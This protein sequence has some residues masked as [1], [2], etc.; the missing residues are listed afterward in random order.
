MNDAFF[1]PSL[2]VESFIGE[3]SSVDTERF[4]LF[5]KAYYEWMQ[6]TTL[7]LTN[8]AGTFVVG[9]TIV[10]TI[11]GAI[12]SI[13]EVKTN[14][15]VIAPTSRTVF[16]YAE[17]LTGQTSGATATINVIKDNVGRASGNILNYKNL[18]IS[19]DKY[20]DYL[21]EELYPSIPAT[22]YGDK[23]LVAQ[24]FKDFY[25]SKSNEQSYRFLFKLLYNEDI[26]FYY[27][28]EDI[29][30]VSDG[31][32]EKT[33]IIRTEA[34]A[35]GVNSS[36]NSFDRDI[37]L[38]LNKTIRGQTSGV[39]ANVVDIKKFFIGS[40]EI[41]EMT[42]KLV[43]GTF[44]AGED[45][46][47]I[48]DD[49]LI[50]TIY[51]ILSGVNII[52]GGSGYADGDIITITGNGS[53]AQARV[54]S[55]KES[56][57]SALSINTV[58]HG[59]QLNTTATINNSGTGGSGLTIQVTELANTYT[60]TSGANTYT[61]GEISEISIISRGEGYF[62]K[63]SIT[64]QDTTIASLG[65]LSNNLITISNAGTNYGVGNT[66]IIT[67]LHAGNSGAGIIASVVETTTFDLLFEDGFQMKADGSYY[68][69]IKNE[70]WLVKGPIKRI[71]LTDFGDG[72]TPGLLPL[73]SVASTTG[74]GANLIATGIQGTSAN[75]TVDTSNNITGI[76]SIRAV[77]ITNFGIN[78]ST[79]N[80]IANTV[81]DGNANLIA[82]ISG[83]GIKDG[84]W[85]G[86]DGKIDYKII[87]DSYYYQDYSYVIKSGL[88][89]ETYS[90]TLKSIIHPAGLIYFGE[91]QIL[92]DISVPS[93]L[94]D[95]LER[96]LVRILSEFSVGGQYADS[97][98]SMTLSVESPLI[99]V[100]TDLNVQEYTI[101]L[102]TQNSADASIE[103][104]A[105]VIQVP[106]E[107]D[108]TSSPL[109]LPT[110]KLV[111]SYINPIPAY[112]IT[113]E[114]IP[115]FSTGVFGDDWINTPISTL[116]SVA[117]SDPYD[118]SPAY[119]SVYSITNKVP[120]VV[121]LEISLDQQYSVVIPSLGFMNYTTE[122]VITTSLT[123]ID[124][125][126]LENVIDNSTSI[127]NTTYVSY[128]KI[129]GTVSSSVQDYA[130]FTLDAFNDVPIDAI[131]GVV[132]GANA[133]VVVGVGTNFA[134][135]FITDDVFVAN[136]Q[137]FIVQ[138][139]FGTSNMVIDRNPETPFSNVVAYKVA[140]PTYAFSS[141]PTSINE[142]AN[143]TFNVATTFV[144]SGT[145]LY[146][147]IDNVTT[148]AGDFL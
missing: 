45:I 37:F 32:F 101:K 139:V 18:E 2:N 51:G 44:A 106:F 120:N 138:A 118:E 38:F 29:L 8:K 69:I 28:G 62:K 131:D 71:E 49:N 24:Y 124:T 48:D 60:V 63:P 107:L 119:Q 17:S 116:A 22:Y 96:M 13:K 36:G 35:T 77:Q 114:D 30:R 95:N 16:A 112:G 93:S 109:Q 146:W 145:T 56:P 140:T 21:R 127:A 113:Y 57:I 130:A 102:L 73:I 12:G 20:V 39:L 83:L 55:I 78:Y 59:Y 9:E 66:L 50:T 85:V 108:V 40:I 142:G 135:D 72:Y 123:S 117:F 132:I 14:S 99:T 137:Y 147:T 15:I 136:N 19:V 89:F 58:G 86:D 103:N 26:D 133:P 41:A 53:E 54:S 111:V 34:T 91:I 23:Q 110:T 84:V 90:D 97:F 98:I 31:N 46:V 115:L 104:R 94:L 80:A 5:M 141:V 11:S 76:G 100:N 10:G 33:Q 74:A 68:D 47:D 148:S 81:G 67:S 75:V 105:F 1:K 143:G 88:A 25:E 92:N 144:G 65:L 87:Q 82:T 61:V 43:S 27:P 79:A 122:S 3:N 134:A 42:L 125:V 52:D 129:S 70:D 64:L 7:S 121:S 128:G 126:Y 6:S 4:L